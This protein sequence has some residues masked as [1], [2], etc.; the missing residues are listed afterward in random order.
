M[1][2]SGLK[3]SVTVAP[4]AF[5]PS[6][7]A[8]GNPPVAGDVL[9]TVGPD[10][11]GT[12]QDDRVQVTVSDGNATF[13]DDTAIDE[14]QIKTEFTDAAGNHTAEFPSSLPPQS[15]QQLSDLINEKL[16]VDHVINLDLLDLPAA[17]DGPKT[18]GQASGGSDADHIL[19]DSSANFPAL[20]EAQKPAVGNLLIN[21][22]DDTHCTITVV[23]T[24]TLTCA[25][26]SAMD[27][28][29]GEDY[30]VVGNGTKDLIV[31]LGIG[32]CS[33]GGLCEANDRDVPAVQAPLN[34]GAGFAD[35]IAVDTQGKME[36]DYDASAQLDIGIPL[37]LDLTP[38]VVVLDTTGV[39][40]EAKLDA[41]DIGFSASLG[42]VSVSLGTAITDTDPDPD[43]ETP[44]VG[45]GK[46]GAELSIGQ[47]DDD[48]VS[49]NSTKTFGAFLSGIGVNFDGTDQECDAPDGDPVEA[50]GHACAVLNIEVAGVK[51]L[52]PITIECNLGDDPLCD[53]TLPPTLEALVSGK[54]LDWTLLLQVLPQ[55]LTNLQKTL[56][57]AAQDIHIPIIGDTLD[58]GADIVGVFNDNIV[59]P[60]STLAQ[61][62]IAAG[63]Q[64]SD[65]DLDAY[66]LAAV[67]QQFIFDKLKDGAGGAGLLEDTNGVDPSGDATIDDI[68]VTPLCGNPATVCANGEGVT[69]NFIRDFRVTFKIGQAIDG[70]VP[71]DVGLKGLPLRLTGGV[72]GNGHWSLLLDFGLSFK[73][74]P[75][76]VANGKK[77]FT[78]TETRPKDVDTDDP[79]D[80]T[81]DEYS[82][83]SY[84]QDDNTDFNGADNAS[85][86]DDLAE[87]GMW[88]ENTTATTGTTGCRV[89]KVEEHKLYCDDFGTD[90]AGTV[91]WN[92]ED[93]Y[94]LRARHA[95]DT[96]DDGGASELTLGASVSMGN[97]PGDAGFTCTD[98]NHDYNSPSTPAYLD[99]FSDDRCLAGELA[100]LQV[101]IRDTDGALDCT[102]LSA[103]GDEPTAVCLEATLDFKKGDGPRV[104][105]SDLIGGN[106]SFAPKLEGNANIDVR[107][108]TGLNT[109]QNAGFP[110]VL[111]KF[112]LFWGFEATP[113]DGL[114]F[115]DLDISFD[116]VNLD[117]GKFISAFLTPIVKQVKDV[118]GPLMPVVEMLQGE[119][120][121]ISDLSKLVGQGP[122]TVLDLLEAVSGND[123]SL[124]R[125]ILQFVKFINTIPTDGNLLIPLGTGGEGGS[126]SVTGER[127]GESQPIPEQAGKGI[128]PGGN[129][130]K[131][132]IDELAKDGGPY[133]KAKA[134]PAECVGRGATFGVCG[135]TFPFLGDAGQIFGV[136]MGQD[137][138]L[139]HYDAGTFGAGAGFGFCFPPIIIGPL[140]IQICIGGSFRV[141]GRF[142]MGYDT[143]GLRKVLEGGTGT[144]L[145]DGIYFDDYNAQGVDVPEIA[146]T[147][148]V[149][150]E[151]SV[152]VYIVKVG[153]RGEI[154]FTMG[155]DLHEDPP[156]DGKI[157]I[158]EIVTKLFTPICLFDVTG[159]IQAAL[160]AFVK[161]DLFITSVEFSI[162][163]VKITL[164]EFK[165]DICTPKPPVLAHTET[166]TGVE[167]LV[168]HMGDSTQRNKRNI[169]PDVINEKFTV[170][171]MESYGAESPEHN[172]KTRFSV[173][174]F[175]IQQDYFMT[176]SKVGTANA[177]LIANADTGDDV[178][179]L[180][181]GGD[182]GTKS[183]P[184]KQNPP[185]PFTLRAD[186]S[187]GTG[188]DDITTGDERRHHRRRSG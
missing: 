8:G 52:D 58:A 43:V 5:L 148:R 86:D 87:V 175:G 101:T 23:S 118:T 135:L 38:D 30:E 122:V 107:F 65:T 147:G 180:L 54:P 177:V 102:T 9:G 16:G 106:F 131:N 124:L 63:D 36:L 42:P 96:P 76:I 132:L 56:D 13:A 35:L 57:G 152:S 51:F 31:S 61:Q 95:P 108:R 29:S 70:D 44:G 99:G 184:G 149:Y 71:F 169:A 133:T 140:P 12:A 11:T 176:T 92:G 141:E 112:H 59:T 50:S 17:G 6:A 145:L 168:L 164:L 80:G 55:I 105:F 26:G 74:G 21:K 33:G 154:I 53:A 109:G 156:Q 27:W 81:N 121:I 123:L 68:V 150:A 139:V 114:D 46:I 162:Q 146:F 166:V 28:D 64:D 138:T 167:R 90:T 179:S 39:S 181:P 183:E 113:S 161:I 117:A 72:H 69:T 119:V 186:I 18:S 127:A 3:G 83:L 157:R 73:D 125:S 136:L 174:A 110:S 172:G 24:D 142:A 159:K 116:G 40:L 14:W 153:I 22:D 163:I 49:N 19:E 77:G 78:G 85:P 88:L 34:V 158:E 41:Q 185:V 7:G 187:A 60:F 151:G 178:I 173:S 45:I 10:E 130:S 120:P 134:A 1:T 115:G 62:I 67:T 37:K 129:T 128:T 15:L 100:F 79:P 47:S 48:D 97:L 93:E 103:D 137:A 104:G 171:Q 4:G 165:L 98:S 155:L 75:Y 111:G 25:L 2:W 144:H 20:P 170:R 32:F 143:S 84:L 182:S 126:F 91:S 82:V 89:T 66:D 160:S 188:D 94:E